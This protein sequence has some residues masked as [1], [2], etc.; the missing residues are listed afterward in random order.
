MLYR[1]SHFHTAHSMPS[2]FYLK[3][4]RPT[5]FHWCT[6]TFLLFPSL[7]LSF[8]IRFT[9]FSQKKVLSSQFWTKMKIAF[10]SL[11]RSIWIRFP[12][13]NFLRTVSRVKF[14]SKEVFMSVFYIHFNVEKFVNENNWNTLVR[15]RWMEC[16]VF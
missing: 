13:K 1:N 3:F 11:I 6:H 4:A 7:P 12:K 14:E 5:N 8:A 10:Q 2:K 9:H 15:V 16:G